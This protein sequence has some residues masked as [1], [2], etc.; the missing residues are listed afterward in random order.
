LIVT[1]RQKA[2]LKLKNFRDRSKMP[3]NEKSI[4]ERGEN[5]GVGEEK[6]PLIKK[7]LSAS[8]RG[9]VRQPG[10]M[11][12]VFNGGEPPSRKIAKR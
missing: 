8:E 6:H 9:G 1:N 2:H 4:A 12:E 10:E 3:K 5:I 7:D 11:G